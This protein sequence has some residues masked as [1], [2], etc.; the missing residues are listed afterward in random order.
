[1][2]EPRLKWGVSFPVFTWVE[3]TTSTILHVWSQWKRCSADWSDCRSLLGRGRQTTLGR[4]L[5]RSATDCIDPNM[6]AAVSKKTREELDLENL[7]GK[8]TRVT[9]IGRQSGAATDAGDGADGEGTFAA[10]GVSR[11]RRRVRGLAAAT[12]WLGT[13]PVD[14]G[15][16]MAESSPGRRLGR[17]VRYHLSITPGTEVGTA[18]VGAEARARTVTWQEMWEGRQCP[19]F[20]LNW[21]FGSRAPF[22]SDSVPTPRQDLVIA[23]IRE[24][25]DRSL[26]TFATSGQRLAFMKLLRGRDVYDTRDGG[27]SLTSF[28]SVSKIS[29]PTTNEGSPRVETVATSETRQS[30]ENGTDRILRSRQEISEMKERLGIIPYWALASN[31]RRYLQLVRALLKRDM[32]SLIEADEVRERVGVVLVEKL[33]TD[34]QRLIIDARV[35]NLHFLT[36]PGVSLVTSEGLS[37]VQ[38]VLENDDVDPGELSRLTGLHLGPS[39]VKDA[40]RRFKIAKLYSSFFCSSW[41]GRSWSGSSFGWTSVLLFLAACGS[42]FE[43]IVLSESNRGGNVGHT[44]PW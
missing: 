23:L 16:P 10:K 35:S 17:C 42:Y 6:R 34:T 12:Q 38:V 13:R 5:S 20:S 14:W 37:R 27:L 43:S 3:R 33:G 2:N 30:P 8:F 18:S 31:Q 7:R 29:M 41:S 36:P 28:R 24:L 44:W 9:G 11:Q 32:V 22:A 15:R 40:F 1:M 25:V 4:S 21:C 39:D 26:P 19:D